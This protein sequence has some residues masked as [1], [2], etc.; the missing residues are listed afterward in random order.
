MLSMAVFLPEVSEQSIAPVMGRSM[1]LERAR[2]QSSGPCVP[3]ISSELD[4]EHI[5]EPR[6]CSFAAA[7]SAVGRSRDRLE[8][9]ARG[10]DPM[11]ECERWISQI[12][13]RLAGLQMLSSIVEAEEMFEGSRLSQKSGGKDALE[14]V[15]E[16]EQSE[17]RAM[18]E[19][20]QRERDFEKT[21][22]GKGVVLLAAQDQSLEGDE[23]NEKEYDD[24][25]QD[26]KKQ[27][28]RAV[29]RVIL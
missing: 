15:D 26:H 2:P 1:P 22:A 4:A 16:E 23:A 9:P 3:G 12:D 27:Q 6:L 20:M 5:L 25:A 13:K 19:D 7:R 11:V 10:D 29:T 28:E 14:G 18:L 24:L 21:A 8:P 17:I